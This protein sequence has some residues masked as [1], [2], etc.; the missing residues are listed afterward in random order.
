[1]VCAFHVIEHVSD[2][3]GFAR[4]L[5][6]CVKPGGRLCIAVP[7]RASAITEIPNFVFNAPPHHLSWW[8]ESA[9]CALAE[10]LDLIV[11]VIEAMPFCSHDSIIYW[12]G[13]FAPKLTRR[14]YFRAHWAW[15]CALAWSWAAGRVGNALFRV[16]ASAA[17]SGLLLVASKRP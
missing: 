17:A 8:N 9:L 5:A 16:P 11:D 2:P 3:L 4:D 15:Y 14:R 10:R 12:M 13:R 7:G 1:M 6:H